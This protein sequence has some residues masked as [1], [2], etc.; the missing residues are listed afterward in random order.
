MKANNFKWKSAHQR[1]SVRR[2]IR[3][4]L[5]A[6]NNSLTCRQTWSAVV[7]RCFGIHRALAPTPLLEALNAPRLTQI[8]V[9]WA[10]ERKAIRERLLGVPTGP[11]TVAFPKGELELRPLPT[12]AAWRRFRRRASI[13][14]HCLPLQGGA[15]GD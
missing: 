12:G 11:N 13:R 7:E 5:L 3:S 1:D 6:H 2:F 14:R 9:L 8:Q 10:E 15:I 4:L